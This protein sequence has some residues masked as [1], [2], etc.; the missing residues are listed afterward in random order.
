VGRLQH[1]DDLRTE[2]NQLIGNGQQQRAR[3]SQQNASPWQNLVFFGQYL[4]RAQGHHT[5]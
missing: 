5:R 4:R 3:T 2:L 1:G